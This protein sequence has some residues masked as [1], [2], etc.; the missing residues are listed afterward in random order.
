MAKTGRLE[1]RADESFLQ[2]LEKLADES[3]TSKATVIDRA[4]GLYKKAL[5]EA[6]KGRSIQFVD[7]T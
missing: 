4:V 2:T 5:E 7:V 6:E 1:I 3:G